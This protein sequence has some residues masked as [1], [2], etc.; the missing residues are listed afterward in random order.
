[1]KTRV[2]IV[3]DEQEFVEALSERL[4]L[5]DY[6]VTT[7]SSGRDAAENVAQYNYDVVV[8]DV[9]MPDM[10]GVE[11]LKRIKGA[12]PL[13]EVIMLTGH[14]TVETAIEGMKLGAYDYLMKPCKDDELFDKIDKASAKKAEHE[15]R[16][17]EAKVK[18]I[19]SSPRS[20]L[21]S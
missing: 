1:M 17:R 5:R 7:S 11:T 6:D 10:D 21:S 2:L 18:E 9:L 20:V 16:I 12:K 4:S 3:D 14:A 13:T 15:E 19:V 8:L